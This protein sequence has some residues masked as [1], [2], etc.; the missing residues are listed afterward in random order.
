V[1]YREQTGIAFG[2]IEA[3]AKRHLR[4]APVVGTSI[5]I[6]LQETGA[7]NVSRSPLLELV[8]GAPL[9]LGLLRNVLP[10]LGSNVWMF[11]ETADW[12]GY[13]LTTISDQIDVT[14]FIPAINSSPASIEVEGALR[15]TAARLIVA[16]S[17]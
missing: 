2:T 10:S 13:R 15:G 3:Y 1:D 8:E 5:R 7:G 9:T 6:S 4:I 16:L 12:S 17:Y 11:G 14:L